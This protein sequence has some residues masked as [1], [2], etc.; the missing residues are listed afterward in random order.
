MGESVWPLPT[1]W[2]KF[3]ALR[4]VLVCPIPAFGGWWRGGGSDQT[5][6]LDGHV[7]FGTFLK[8]LLGPRECG[9]SS[10]ASPGPGEFGVHFWGCSP[11]L[12]G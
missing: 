2:R 4:G 7:L 5:L 11:S 6:V 8:K 3:P 10:A 9:Q 1:G 12:S